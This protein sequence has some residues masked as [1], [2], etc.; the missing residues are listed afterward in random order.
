[1]AKAAKARMTKL[2]RYRFDPSKTIIATVDSFSTVRLDYN[3]YSVP[4]KYVSK[5]VSTKGYG[6][7]LII[8]YRNMEIARYH[9][10]YERGKTKYQL[11]Y[12]IDLIE[13]RPRSVFN[14]RPVLTARPRSG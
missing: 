7:E 11:T 3:H 4:V 6:N 1:M 5:E 8:M 13:K 12:Y 10:C 2:P 14:A 9:R